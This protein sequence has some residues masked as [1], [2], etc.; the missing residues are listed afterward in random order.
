MSQR[1]RRMSQNYYYDLIYDS[2]CMEQRGLCLS[3]GQKHV[4]S[5]YQVFARGSI[6][7]THDWVGF[8]EQNVIVWD[9]THQ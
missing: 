1:L 6:Q 9:D 4:Q 8:I 3:I 7:L 2:V 5:I